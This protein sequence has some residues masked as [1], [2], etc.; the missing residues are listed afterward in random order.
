MFR[1]H[2]TY[3]LVKAL[4][5]GEKRFFKLFASK[6][7]KNR[8][9]NTTQL[10]D[11]FDV[12]KQWNQKEVKQKI[13]KTKINKYTSVI[14]NKLLVDLITSL[15]LQEKENSTDFII[16]KY[17]EEAKILFQREIYDL[18]LDRIKKARVLAED[19]EKLDKLTEVY[20]T[21]KYISVRVLDNESFRMFC[22]DLCRRNKDVL[23]KIENKA[24]Y[25][26]L[27]DEMFYLYRKIGSPQTDVQK[28]EYDKVIQS[29]HLK[30]VK[31]AKTISAKSSYYFAY[32]IYYLSKR[33]LKKALKVINK[34]IHTIEENNKYLLA[35]IDQ[36]VSVLNNALFIHS[37]LTNEKELFD[38]FTKM[39]LMPKKYEI[40]S[41]Y[42]NRRIFETTYSMELDHYIKKVDIP[43]LNRVLPIIINGLDKYGK[44]GWSLDRFMSMAFGISL[45]YFYQSENKQAHQ[46]VDK[47]LNREHEKS[48]IQILA[49]AKVLDLVLHY[50][51]ENFNL[52]SYRITS[53]KR[54]LK[55][56]NRL[57]EIDDAFFKMIQQVLKNRKKVKNEISI[58]VIHLQNC[59]PSATKLFYKNYIRIEEWCNSKLN[60][61]LLL[62][63]LK[64]LKN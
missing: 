17:I 24:I 44:S 52:L 20:N 58:F 16:N 25:S 4:T 7:A 13:S 39:R 60:N 56:Y 41:T 45:V 54:F 12:T 62:K 51:L 3:Q 49:Y 19:S 47:I 33:Q 64:P 10:F 6:Y 31:K 40:H 57:H 37:E 29:P 32:T 27:T 26:K 9:N 48:N 30:D 2:Q 35:N 1:L 53:V 14:N 63:E 28:E 50:D 34:Q 38:T 42:F 22:K 43:S 23:N 15:R 46:W 5:R 61:T 21:E 11:I 59:P 18:A 8:K 55:K 36:Y